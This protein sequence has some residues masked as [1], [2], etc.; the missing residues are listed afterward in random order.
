VLEKPVRLFLPVV[1]L[2]AQVVSPPA[3]GGQDA[4]PGPF[5]LGVLRR[6]G[7][8]SP[9]AAFDGKRWEAP[10]PGNLRYLELPISLEEVPGRWWGKPGAPAEMSV[11]ADG[12]A[13]GTLRL[14]RPTMVRVMCDSRLALTSSY[15]S[16]E[17]APPP[18]VQ[19]YPKDGLAISG[20]QTIEAIE[21]LPRTAP[22]WIPTALKLVEPFDRA[23]LVAINAFTAWKH[24]IARKERQKVP[25]ELEMLYRAPMDADGWTSYYVEAIKRY[26]PGPDDGDCGLITSAKGWI[27]QGPDRKGRVLL[28]ARVTYCDRRDVTFVLPLGLIKARGKNYWVYQLSGYGRETYVVARPRPQLIEPQIYYEAGFCGQG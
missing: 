9:F 20:S 11:W 22:E 24:P 16:K 18:V 23:E 5:V 2:I 1:L 15:R 8:V 10:W 13:R 27:T 17:V 14:E 25:V 7:L 3:P 19:P 4:D 28:T 21:I 26:P 6:D 12:S